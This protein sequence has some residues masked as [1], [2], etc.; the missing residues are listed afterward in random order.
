MRIDIIQWF[1]VGF[2]D[3][4]LLIRFVLFLENVSFLPLGDFMP[5]L[6]QD[7]Q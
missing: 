4:N 3:V 5:H 1:H 2:Y 6:R 7:V